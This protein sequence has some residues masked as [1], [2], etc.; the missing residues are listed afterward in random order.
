MKLGRNWRY[1]STLSWSQSKANSYI[2]IAGRIHLYEVKQ[3]F[4]LK[5]SGEILATRLDGNDDSSQCGTC[6]AYHFT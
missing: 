4:T 6:N 3:R 1:S 5:W 2:D